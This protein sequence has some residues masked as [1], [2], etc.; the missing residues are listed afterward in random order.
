[1]LDCSLFQ[2]SL[3]IRIGTVV[4]DKDYLGN[5]VILLFNLSHQHF[6]VS[7]GDGISQLI[8]QNYCLSRSNLI[9]ID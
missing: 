2:F 3:F 9:L 8:M 6:I 7:K 5:I 4:I 1:M